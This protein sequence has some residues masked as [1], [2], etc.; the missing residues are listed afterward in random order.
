MALASSI[1]YFPMFDSII[2]KLLGTMLKL[3]SLNAV[4]VV[5]IFFFLRLDNSLGFHWANNGFKLKIK[6]RNRNNIISF[7]FNATA[8]CYKFSHYCV[9]EII[10]LFWNLIDK[11]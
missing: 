9:A 2:K 10:S 7:I 11:N 4:D 6:L 8:V 1:L 5:D 3:S